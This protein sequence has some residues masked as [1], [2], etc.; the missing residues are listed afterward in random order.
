MDQ[1]NR[2]D[3]VG[4]PCGCLRAGGHDAALSRPDFAAAGSSLFSLTEPF[5]LLLP[6]PAPRRELRVLT[7]HQPFQGPAR[8]YGAR[9]ES[10]A[11]LNHFNRA[12]GVTLPAI[13]LLTCDSVQGA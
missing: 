3:S 1:A 9:G 6:S 13:L 2:P 8:N 11:S 12:C 10:L 5:S 4:E 7:K